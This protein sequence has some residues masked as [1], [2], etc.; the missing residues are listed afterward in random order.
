MLQTHIDIKYIVNDLNI[1]QN[2]SM[3]KT[4]FKIGN[5]PI[6]F[7]VKIMQ[8]RP[9]VDWLTENR[10]LKKILVCYCISSIES[11]PQN[12]YIYMVSFGLIS[13]CQ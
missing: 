6:I 13:V 9:N 11:V 5:P 7:N 8:N 12:K 10:K 1:R 3:T 4:Q 2:D